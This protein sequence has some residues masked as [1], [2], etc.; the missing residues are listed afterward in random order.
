[1]AS[2]KQYSLKR[3]DEG[4]VL[5]GPKLDRSDS[6]GNSVWDVIPFDSERLFLH[7]KDSQKGMGGYKEGMA[8]CT[9][10]LFSDFLAGLNQRRFS[11]V[12]SADTGRGI[13]RLF[14]QDGDVIFAASNLI[15]D[16]LGEVIYRSGMITL[17]QMA[18]SAVKVNRSNKFGK[19]LLNSGIFTTVDLWHALKFQVYEIVRS[20]FIVN[21]A[22][23]QIQKGVG[24]APTAVVFKQG[25]QALIE[26][27]SSYGSMFRAFLL[28][29]KDT[30]KLKILEE[31]PDWEEPLP[32]TFR[33][34][35][36]DLIRKTANIGE[37]VQ[38]SKLKD[39][40]TYAA[41]FHLVNDR[42][43][44]L[45]F[46]EDEAPL[47]FPT[48]LAHLKDIKNKLDAYDVLFRT[49]R[50]A[51][52]QAKVEFPARDIRRFVKTLSNGDVVTLF[53][54]ENA[55]IPR[56]CVFNIFHQCKDN[57]S[58]TTQVLF[59]LQSLIQ[60]L[61]QVTTDL[62]PAEIGN[63]VKTKFQELLS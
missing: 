22:Y 13:K 48:N 3:S 38:K 43:C 1:M 47:N 18:E 41:L 7:T 37:L 20:V 51:F 28:R 62:L 35:M 29:I 25:T 21:S 9:V 12:V 60:F 63:E 49:S 5:N 50:R 42:A 30:T 8:K 58:R 11:G 53:I 54:E 27:C 26:E 39:I 23:F 57:H 33:G 16:R 15:D 46:E 55:S 52:E 10:E 17:E 24:L 19:V 2:P 36:I 59:L 31:H 34:D 45:V 61:L 4:L 14:F 6:E 40:N 56:D 32:G 44:Q